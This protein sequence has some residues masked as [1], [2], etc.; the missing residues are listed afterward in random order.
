MEQTT[1]SFDEEI[2][3]GERFRFG[4]NWEAFLALVDDDRI[5]RAERSLAEMLHAP[6]LDGRSFLDIG[7]GSGLFSLAARRLGARVFSFD[8]D[9]ASVGCTQALKDRFSPADADWEVSRGSVLD[10]PFMERLPRY[11]IV[12]SWGVLHH[13]GRMAEAID[14]AVD[15]VANGGVLFV[16][17]YRKTWLCPFWK[18]EKRAYCASPPAIQQA[19]RAAFGAT[20]GLAYRATHSGQIPP[21]GMDPEKDLHDW[22]GGYPYE[23]IAPRELK[24]LL[25][26]RGMR[27]R[28]QR[29]K[30]QGVAVT[31]GCDQYVFSRQ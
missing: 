21:R 4:E 8:Y 7:S 25:A 18:L 29:V 22:L 17:L 10:R 16:A 23:S 1:R 2:A 6:R 5:A 15:R 31:P 20:L 30:T 11:D 12:Y 28:E 27:L 14:N 26:K 9:P 3:R 24:A 19:I 13:T